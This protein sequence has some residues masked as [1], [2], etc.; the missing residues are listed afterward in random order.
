[1]TRMKPSEYIEKALR[2]NSGRNDQNNIPAQLEH[3]II[4][5]VTESGEL[6][7]VVKKGRFQGKPMDRINVIE[8]IGDI[9]WYI[10]LACDT[11]NVTLEEIMQKNIDKLSARYPEKFAVDKSENRN[12]IKE[13]EILE[14]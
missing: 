5:M 14:K 6:A 9:M 3:A 10:A 2:T 11:L 13:R 4:G 7:D 1:M 8:E 12:L